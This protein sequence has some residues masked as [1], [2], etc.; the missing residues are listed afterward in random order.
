M[1]SESVGPSEDTLVQMDLFLTQRVFDENENKYVQPQDNL[2]ECK[3]GA[4]KG[5]SQAC[6]ALTLKSSGC[7]SDYNSQGETKDHR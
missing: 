5:V 6:K 7:L 3:F 1:V 2:T 4:V